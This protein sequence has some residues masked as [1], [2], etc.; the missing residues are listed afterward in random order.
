M[1]SI[2]SK[3][4]LVSRPAGRSLFRRVLSLLG[5][6]IDRRRERLHLARLDQHLLRDIG[7]EA[8]AVRDECA[9]PFWQP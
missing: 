5:T 7:L 8:D 9:K 1:A 2:Q 4:L 3:T 6:T